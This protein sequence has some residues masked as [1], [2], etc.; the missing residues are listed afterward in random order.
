MN[1]FQNSWHIFRRFVEVRKSNLSSKSIFLK[2][3]ILSSSF[4]KHLGLIA[5]KYLVPVCAATSFL[6]SPIVSCGLHL[7][8]TFLPSLS[9]TITSIIFYLKPRKFQNCQNFFTA[10]IWHVSTRLFFIGIH[11]MGGEVRKKLHKVS[12]GDLWSKT[13]LGWLPDDDK[14]WEKWQ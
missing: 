8:L 4:R 9:L 5:K 1:Q 14:K 13:D 10:Q 7:I 3:F 6:K 2:R 12:A 11:L